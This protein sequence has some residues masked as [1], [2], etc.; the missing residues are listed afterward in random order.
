[1]AE[2][3]SGAAAVCKRER[4]IAQLF[5]SFH[6]KANIFPLVKPLPNIRSQ[7]LAHEPSRRRMH[8]TASVCR[9][10]GFDGTRLPTTDS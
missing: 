3:A 2:K 9:S 6:A 7:E 4:L 1:L 8:R 5:C 10:V